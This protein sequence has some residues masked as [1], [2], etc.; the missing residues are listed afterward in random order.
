MAPIELLTDSESE[1]SDTVASGQSVSSARGSPRGLE[2]VGAT[3]NAP[4]TLPDAA[5]LRTHAPPPLNEIFSWKPDVIMSDGA[6]AGDAAAAKVFARKDVLKEPGGC[7]TLTW[8]GWGG[9]WSSAH[10]NS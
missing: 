5:R 8:V 7:T 10:Q 9:E 3:I 1:D 2:G 4:G 6:T